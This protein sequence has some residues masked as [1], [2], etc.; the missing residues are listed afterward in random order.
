MTLLV[1]SVDVAFEMVLVLVVVVVVVVGV[2]VGVVAVGRLELARRVLNECS[3]PI[4]MRYRR[5]T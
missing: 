2:G 4:P 5:V 3:E 1:V